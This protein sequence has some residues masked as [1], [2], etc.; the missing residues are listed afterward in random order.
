[1]GGT[2][3]AVC[4]AVEDAFPE[5]RL[6]LEQLPLTPSRVW[7]AIQDAEPK[8]G[9]WRQPATSASGTRA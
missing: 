5:R 4:A 9:P 7:R 2:L 3:A 8:E 1:M 6:R